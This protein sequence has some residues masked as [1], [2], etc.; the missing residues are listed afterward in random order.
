MTA[1]TAPSLHV[2]RQ[3][4][5]DA[6]QR[7][8]A[9]LIERAQVVAQI[10][11]LKPAG[12]TAWR[13][14]REAQILRALL[15]QHSGS[16]P[17]AALVHIWRILLSTFC[18]MQ[19]PLLL[20]YVRQ[21]NYAAEAQ[22]RDALRANFGAMIHLTPYSTAAEAMQVTAINALALT[23][24]PTE[25][26]WWQHLP[27]NVQVV[28]RLPFVQSADAPAPVWYVLAQGTPEASGHDVAL[29]SVPLPAPELALQTSATSALIAMPHGHAAPANATP[30]GM[31]PQPCL[32]NGS[33]C[34]ILP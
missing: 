32:F 29:F 11:A 22:Q 21:H 12:S 34:E 1:D 24:L 17:V 15:A 9:L 30:V 25:G 20:N 33:P 19:V 4:I 14:A 10:G 7:L 27:A 6:D 28:A 23:A 31:Y 26:D 16:M 13:P 5:D 8:H 3:K 18:Q 2:L